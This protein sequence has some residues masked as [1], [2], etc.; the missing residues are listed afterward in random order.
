MTRYAPCALRNARAAKCN[1]TYPMSLPGSQGVSMPSFMPIGPKLWAL[2]GLT[3]TVT[4][5]HRQTVLLLL[6]RWH[7]HAHTHTHFYTYFLT[8]LLIIMKKKII[9]PVWFFPGIH[10]MHGP[11]HLAKLL[12]NLTYLFSQNCTLHLPP[13]LV[14]RSHSLPDCKDNYT[15]G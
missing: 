11:L 4:Q 3:H 2:E 1:L 6:Y 8:S 15:N 5:T 7:I 10:P 12:C 13:P 9:W 14:E